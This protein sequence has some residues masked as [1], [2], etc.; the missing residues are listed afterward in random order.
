LT[1]PEGFTNRGWKNGNLK[2]LP[3]GKLT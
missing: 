2:D 1:S 3:S